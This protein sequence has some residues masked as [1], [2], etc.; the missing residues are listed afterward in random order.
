MKRLSPTPGKALVLLS[1]V[2][3]L[4]TACTSAPTPVSVPLTA[5]AV[6]PTPTLV[7]PTATAIQPTAT[8][9]VPTATSVL[10]T[11]TPVPPT[12]TPT[13]IQPTLTPVPPTA[14]PT[15]I[16]PTSTPVPPTVTPTVTALPPTSTPVPSSTA[17]VPPPE[18]PDD[19]MFR[20][21]FNA[22]YLLGGEPNT[23][24]QVDEQICPFLDTKKALNG[25]VSIYDTN[26]RIE[27]ANKGFQLD[28][29][30]FFQFCQLFGSQFALPP[31]NYEY[32]FR[33]GNSL[34]A[35]LPIQVQPT[36]TDAPA[37]SEQPDAE[38]FRANFN[39]IYISNT[40]PS[41]VFATN[42]RI[43][44]YADIKKTMPV[45]SGSMYDVNKRS[46]FFLQKLTLLTSPQPGINIRFLSAGAY[47]LIPGKYEARFWVDDTLVAVLPLE[48]R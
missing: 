16:P 10:P 25:N 41:T 22:L 48:V 7:P 26:G 17:T 28:R 45:L 46:Y 47:A 18:K 32:K 4:M 2:I 37:L 20:A 30:G 39:S 3:A 5:T 9:V 42:A 24:F 8:M 34:A 6:Q 27:I 33:V 11:S 12:A 21:Y 44:L 43:A 1:V 29:A 31:G 40:R 19:A 23:V 14:T 38:V 15:R 13:R 35:V 36:K